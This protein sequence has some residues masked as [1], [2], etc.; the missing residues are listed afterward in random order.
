M[1][2]SC[3]WRSLLD[4]SSGYLPMSPEVRRGI[5]LLLWCKLLNGQTVECD[6]KAL[7]SESTL[8][9]SCLTPP[10]FDSIETMFF[11]LF[12][13]TCGCGGGGVGQQQ[14]FI[15]EYGGV[16][17]GITPTAT[18]AVALDKDEGNN[19]WWWDGTTW[20]PPF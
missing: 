2:I 4:A 5:R 12:V 15:G 9:W 20:G 11:C 8:Y 17:P 1:P 14:V 3:E 6:P 16:A 19:V 13:N 18:N 10:Q 7:M